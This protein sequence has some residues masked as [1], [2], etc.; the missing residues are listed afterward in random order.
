[1][2]LNDYE[3]KK[4]LIMLA[5]KKVKAKKMKTKIKNKKIKQIEDRITKTK[6]RKKDR[7]IIYT[8]LSSLKSNLFDKLTTYFYYKQLIHINKTKF[9]YVYLQY[10]KEYLHAIFNKNIEFNLINLKRFY[11]NS[12]ILSESIRLKLTKN[13]RRILKYLNKLKDKVKIKQKNVLIRPTL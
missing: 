2:L 13:R 7:H 10:L 5:L 8:F 11:L 4:Y 6:I 9:N 3:I 12:D 1:V